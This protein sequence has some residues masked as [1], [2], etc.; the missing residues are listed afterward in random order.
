MFGVS[1]SKRALEL[2]AKDMLKGL[3]TL[4]DWIGN[5]SITIND[6]KWNGRFKNSGVRLMSDPVGSALSGHYAWC[7]TDCKFKERTAQSV[8]ESILDSPNMHPHIVRMENAAI[9]K[10]WLHIQ[11]GYRMPDEQIIV[12]NP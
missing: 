9:T 10:N 11:Y 6:Y 7:C 8:Q 5:E 12:F 3:E 2:Y 1:R 4:S